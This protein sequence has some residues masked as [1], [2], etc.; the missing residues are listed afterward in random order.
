MSVTLPQE[1]TVNKGVQNKVRQ[2][3]LLGLRWAGTRTLLSQLAATAAHRDRH[4][5]LDVPN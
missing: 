4:T 5:Q 2:L 3:V 1:T